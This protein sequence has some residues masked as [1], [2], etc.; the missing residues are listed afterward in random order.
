VDS[1]PDDATLF[2]KQKHFAHYAQDFLDFA[3][4]DEYEPSSSLAQTASESADHLNS[5][6]TLLEIYDNL[7]CSR[8][9]TAVRVIIQREFVS[10]SKQVSFAIKIAN[11]SIV[12]THK[13][14]VA[15]EA[16]LMRNDLRELQDF[17]DSIKLP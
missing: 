14:G 16:T 12:R 6:S 2:K 5:A 7:S 10:Y 8:D 13:P 15:A 4:A 3:K 17:F 11:L 1:H 9:R